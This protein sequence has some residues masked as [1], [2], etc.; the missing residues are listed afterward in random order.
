MTKRRTRRQQFNDF[1]DAYKCVKEGKK[2]KRSRAKDGSISTH[3]VVEVEEWPESDVLFQCLQWLKQ[4]YIFCDR[5]NVGAGEMGT[6]GFHS[7]GIKNA[8]DIVGALPNGIHFEIE[9]KRGSGGRLSEGQQK[10]M[11]DV[12]NTNSTYFIVHGIEELE[13]Y[14][15]EL[16]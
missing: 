16:I 1:A 11:R 9:C 10:R 13:Y 3:P 14:M 8:G 15:K 6:S 4:H 12:R 7:Y 5:N 2:V